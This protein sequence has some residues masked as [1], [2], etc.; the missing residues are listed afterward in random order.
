MSCQEHCQHNDPCH[1]DTNQGKGNESDTTDTSA[2]K[3]ANVLTNASADS[4]CIGNVSTNMSTDLLLDTSV[5][6][7]SLP[8]PK[9]GL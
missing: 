4:Q 5:G 8:S 6:L 2:N 7:D 1:Q 9:P 3:P